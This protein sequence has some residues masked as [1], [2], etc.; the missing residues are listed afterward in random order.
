MQRARVGVVLETVGGKAPR[1][2]CKLGKE[3]N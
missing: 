3:K 1:I 2:L